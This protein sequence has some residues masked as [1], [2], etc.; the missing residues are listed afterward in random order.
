MPHLKQGEGLPIPDSPA[1]WAA[2]PRGRPLRAHAESRLAGAQSDLP[3][4][5]AG[6][7][8]APDTRGCANHR[9]NSQVDWPADTSLSGR[10]ISPARSLGSGADL[11]QGSGNRDQG[12]ERR[13]G[14][15]G[16]FTGPG[17]S[18]LNRKLV[19]NCAARAVRYL[20]TTRPGGLNSPCERSREP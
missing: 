12:S 6:R 11:I 4:P 18:F 7:C 1:A 15:R 19:Q 9:G 2:R 17:P 10:A 16:A 13:A 20:N 3:W 5:H 8:A 14:S